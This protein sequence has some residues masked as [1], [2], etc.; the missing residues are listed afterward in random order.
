MCFYVVL[1]NLNVYFL[2]A[3]FMK[4][5]R[6]VSYT[7]VEKRLLDHEVWVEYRHQLLQTL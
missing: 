2:P 3:G 7:P 5:A 4:K 6:N 1:D